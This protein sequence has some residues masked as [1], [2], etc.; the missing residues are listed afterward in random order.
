MHFTANE[1]IK[2]EVKPHILI[3]HFFKIYQ[4]IAERFGLALFHFEHIFSESAEPGLIDN[5]LLEMS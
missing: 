1:I 4:L 5:S 2:G 3:E